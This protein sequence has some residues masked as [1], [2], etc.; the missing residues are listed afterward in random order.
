MGVG[1]P[2]D[3]NFDGTVNSADYTIWANNFGEMAPSSATAAVPEPSSLA[4]FVFGVA[5]LLYSPKLAKK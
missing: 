4:L 5:L 1:L 2:A 3:G